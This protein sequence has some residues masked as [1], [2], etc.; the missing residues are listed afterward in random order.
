MIADIDADSI[1]WF[2]ILVSTIS[3]ILLGIKTRQ[4]KRLLKLLDDVSSE[5]ET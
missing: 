5:D 1:K 4:C 3:T 2:F